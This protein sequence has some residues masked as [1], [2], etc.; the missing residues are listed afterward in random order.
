MASTTESGL[1]A[2]L[3]RVHG[4][5]SREFITRAR[6]LVTRCFPP[7]LRGEETQVDF[8]R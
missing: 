3:F 4:I 2:K 5:A 8:N 1:I 6:L 7:L